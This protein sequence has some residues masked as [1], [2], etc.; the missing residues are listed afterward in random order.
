MGM[1]PICPTQWPREILARE[2]TVVLMSS[3]KSLPVCAKLSES[4]QCKDAAAAPSPSLA[5]ALGAPALPKG[6]CDVCTASK[7]P[8]ALGVWCSLL[9]CRCRIPNAF[10]MRAEHRRKH[11]AEMP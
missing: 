3:Q 10:R 2:V 4:I 5:S 11:Q 6:L 1:Q 7:P 8:Q 9:T